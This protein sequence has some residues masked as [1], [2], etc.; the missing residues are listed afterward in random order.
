MIIESLGRHFAVAS[1]DEARLM[2]DRDRGF[3]NVISIHESCCGPA[4][5]PGAK[6][7]H[8]LIFDDAEN[9]SED[10][11]WVLA[12]ETDIRGAFEFAD[13]RAGAAIGPLP[14]WRFS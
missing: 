13:A 11:S 4:K 9:P 3:W 14:C 6:G 8:R 2:V 10:G 12:R 7:V 5:L 1:V